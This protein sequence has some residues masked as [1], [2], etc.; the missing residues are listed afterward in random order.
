MKKLIFTGVSGVLFLLL[1]LLLNTYD[2]AAIGPAGTEIGFAT[3]NGNV[4]DALG[5]NLFWY[6]LT[7]LFGLLAL[8]ICGLF[9]L[10][11]LVQ[12]L[13]R[14]SLLAVDHHILAL[15]VFYVLVVVFYV[16]FELVIVNY[17]P[18]IMLGETLP[19]ASFPSSHSMLIC[20]VMGSTAMM[21]QR[22]VKNR[23]LRL[24]LQS[25]CGL[26]AAVTVAGRLLSGVHWLTD[27]IGGVLLSCTLLGL[28]SIGVE[29][30]GL[31]LKRDDEQ[32]DE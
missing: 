30:L 23:D 31:A 6:D 21:L 20:C 12:M 11:G 17:R 28:L 10:K 25:G 4:R 5:V 1:L 27:I 15:G 29:V 16:L 2:V 19:E 8:A 22:Y 26:V 9:G 7:E 3:L 18:V 13:K 24:G 14:R 32:C